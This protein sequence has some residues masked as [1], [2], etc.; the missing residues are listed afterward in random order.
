MELASRHA[1]QREACLQKVCGA[2]G[3]GYSGGMVCRS[4]AEVHDANPPGMADRREAMPYVVGQDNVRNFQRKVKGRW[5][6][7][8]YEFYLPL[9][10][11]GL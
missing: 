6:V 2:C 1:D 10:V 8:L 4:K 11:P 7:E 3:K 5:L 9:E